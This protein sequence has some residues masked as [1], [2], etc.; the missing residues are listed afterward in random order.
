MAQTTAYV[1]GVVKA[2]TDIYNSPAGG[3]MPAHFNNRGDHLIAQSLPAKTELTRMG[4][5]WDCA[6]ATANAFTYVAAWPTT[7]GELVLYNGELATGKSYLIDSA[8]LYNITSMAAAQAMTLIAQIAAVATVPTDDTAQLISSPSGR[9]GYNGKGKR[10]IA[11]TAA[12]QTTN[13]WRVLATSQM[14]AMT[15]NLGAA[16]FAELYGGW[17]VPPGYV[18]ALNA[19]AGTAAGTA[20]IGVRWHEVQLT[21]G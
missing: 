8:W 4:Q 10:A 12:G 19:V 5:T 13:L 14:A 18:F 17:I 2:G 6:I 11:N 20:I 16:L 3:E 15:T 1:S 9:V 7:R 21:L